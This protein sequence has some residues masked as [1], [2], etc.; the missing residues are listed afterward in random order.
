MSRKLN[1]V[2]FIEFHP[3]NPPGT[4]CPCPEPVCHQARRRPKKPKTGSK[5]LQ[6]GARGFSENETGREKNK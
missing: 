2:F 1:M 3:S 5:R 6:S 4:L